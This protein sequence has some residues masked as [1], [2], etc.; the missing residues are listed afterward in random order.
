[1]SNLKPLASLLVR[2]NAINEKITALIDRPAIRGH[3][4]E[5]IAQKIFKVKLH[6]PRVFLDT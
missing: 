3:I 2:R 5:W 1:M 6:R 4:G